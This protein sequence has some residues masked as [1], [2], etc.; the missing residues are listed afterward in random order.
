M[1]DSEMSEWV[2][3]SANFFQP[4]EVVCRGSETQFQVGEKSFNPC[5][6]GSLYMRFQ[7]FLD[8]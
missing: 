4:L 7:G 8:Q 2:N 5:A 1:K 3:G 6:S